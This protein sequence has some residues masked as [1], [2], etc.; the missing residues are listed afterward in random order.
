[1]T[2]SDE[3]AEAQLLSVSNYYFEDDKG[4]P[5]CFSMLP[6]RWSE[7]ES[8]VGKKM[9]MFLR[10]FADNGLQKIFVQVAAWRFDL[11]YVR[12]EILVLS[13][14]GKWI[15]LEKPRKSYEE[16]IRTILITIHF[17]SYVKRNPDS[18][19][20]SAW[21]YLSKNK[22]FR[23]YEVMPSQND[24]LNHM[25]LMGEA[26]KRDAGLAK[27]KVYPGL[28]GKFKDELSFRTAFLLL[29]VR[30]DKNRLKIKKLSEEEVKDL[31]RPGFIIDD[32]DNDLVDEIGEESDGEDGLFDSVCAICDNGGELLCCD[33][34]CMRSFHANEEDGEESNCASL[35]FSQKEVDNTCVEVLNPTAT[36]ESGIIG[37]AE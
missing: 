27:S 2:S 11:S 14:N 35:G 26:M 22:E 31:A 4:A 8:P 25:T 33:G 19:A 21:D 24:V 29:M 20:K 30:E 13:N 34:K 36:E 37:D 32:T 18:S 7:S 5:V 23:S 9:Q 6:I 16:T 28:R 10:G 1:M 12:P 3:E 15:K 17:L